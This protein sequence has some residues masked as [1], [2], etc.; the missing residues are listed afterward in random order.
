[1]TGLALKPY[2]TEIIYNGELLLCTHPTTSIHNGRDTIKRGVGRARATEPHLHCGWPA[3]VKLARTA[4]D[5]VEALSIMPRV[6]Q[7]AFPQR[8]VGPATVA[9]RDHRLNVLATPRVRRQLGSHL[10]KGWA[11][12]S[13]HRA[14]GAGRRVQGAGRRAQGAGCRVQSARRRPSRSRRTGGRAAAARAATGR[15][16]AA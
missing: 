9:A 5:E 4:F 15:P 3:A 11:Y 2:R 7:H 1:M 13:E 12:G 10:L 6:V 8:T 16:A 14:Q